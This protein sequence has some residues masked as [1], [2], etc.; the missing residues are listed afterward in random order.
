MNGVIDCSLQLR[1]LH[2]H[3]GSGEWQN[4]ITHKAMESFDEVSNSA[5]SATRTTAGIYAWTLQK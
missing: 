2:L 5:Q 4:A 1:G 3:V